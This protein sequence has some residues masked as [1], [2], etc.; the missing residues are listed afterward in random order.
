MKTTQQICSPFS[1]KA[2]TEYSLAMLPAC[3]SV[4]VLKYMYIRECVCVR[5]YVFVCV[6]VRVCVCQPPY[7]YVQLHLDIHAS[8][9][10]NCYNNIIDKLG[11]DGETRICMQWTHNSIPVCTFFPPR[12]TVT[13]L[14][15]LDT[16]P[17]YMHKYYSNVV[18]YQWIHT[19][20]RTQLL[21]IEL[22]S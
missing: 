8:S 13:V 14:L 7:P 2:Q 17:M 5:V 4:C 16:S 12:P 18:D 22:F 10:H 1:H 19:V 9:Y 6:C 15:Q 21:P 3:V 20:V 11:K